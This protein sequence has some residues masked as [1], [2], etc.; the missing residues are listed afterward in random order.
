L[1]ADLFSG[2]VTRAS[3]TLDRL[4]E[5]IVEGSEPLLMTEQG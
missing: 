1:L 5:R 3:E 2:A 4:D